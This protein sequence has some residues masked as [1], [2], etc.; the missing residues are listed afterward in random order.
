MIKVTLNGV[1]RGCAG[2]K[3]VKQKSFKIF[4]EKSVLSISD[5]HPV[6]FVHFK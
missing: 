1:G 3:E 5:L 6:H 2:T 4:E